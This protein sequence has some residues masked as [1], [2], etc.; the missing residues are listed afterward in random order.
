M[1]IEQI[2]AG[3]WVMAITR[4]VRQDERGIFSAD[5]R[6]PDASFFPN[7]KKLDLQ[8]AALIVLLLRTAAP[9]VVVSGWL[10]VTDSAA[11]FAGLKTETSFSRSL[12][13]D[14]PF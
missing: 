6:G 7:G 3:R 2:I 5:S 14:S 10:T 12:K 9:I 4:S 8:V 11:R 1:T 13:L